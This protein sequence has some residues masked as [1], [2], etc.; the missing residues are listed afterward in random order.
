MT[1]SWRTI[2]AALQQ[3]DVPDVTGQGPFVWPLNE[4]I[5]QIDVAS[6]AGAIQIIVGDDCFPDG[7]SA[8][9]VLSGNEDGCTRMRCGRCSIVRAASETD[10]EF[11][12]RAQRLLE[13]ACERIVA[14]EDTF[15][16]GFET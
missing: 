7:A 15:L 10:E 12:R 13:R 2:R 9:Q 8:C 11:G 5:V 14:Y 6:D 3:V 16:V 4:A 1:D